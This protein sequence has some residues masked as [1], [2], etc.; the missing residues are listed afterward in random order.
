LCWRRLHDYACCDVRIRTG[1]SA[2]RPFVRELSTEAFAPFGDYR[3]LLPRWTAEPGVVTYVAE[4]GPEPVGFVM[5]GFYY[6]DE[7]RSWC[8]ADVLAIAVIPP[9]RGGGIGRLLLRQAVEAAV[10]AQGSLDVREVR[11][12]VADSNDL[13]QGLFRSESF[14]STEE[15]HGKYDGGQVALRMRRA[16]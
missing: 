6:G 2:D 10:E 5:V 7:K 16:I 9:R 4:D 1:T 13:A 11:L 15:K 3:E 12:T 8:Y 14:E